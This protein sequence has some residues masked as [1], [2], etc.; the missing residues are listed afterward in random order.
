MR[1]LK[2]ILLL[3]FV[4]SATQILVSQGTLPIY[5][6]YLSDN[7]FMVHPS[8]AGIGNSAK[9]RMTHRQQWNSVGNSPSLQ[10]LSLHNAINENVA[11]GGLVFNDKNGFHSQVGLQGAFAYHLNFRNVEA[12]NQLSFGLAASYVQNT[13]DQT[14]FSE[15]DPVVSQLV[16]SDSYFNADVSFAYHYLDGFAFLTVK[17]ILLNTRQ[18]NNPEF[19]SLNLRRYLFN[20]GYFIGRGENLQFE[21]SAMFQY[22]EATNEKLIDLNAKVYQTFGR[23]ARVW[24][25]LSYRR[26]LDNNAIQE[27]SVLTPI[28]GIEFNRFLISYTYTH[29]L[30]GL[31]AREGGFHQLTLGINLLNKRIS[32]RGY[33]SRYNSFLYKTDN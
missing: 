26:S 17:N 16:E 2:Y 15:F 8:A 5:S 24:F 31:I 23:T 4:A 10:T 11:L 33:N 3:G 18:V 9:L 25:A 6:D 32:N 21:P 30:S 19:R 13:L 20:L 29:Q 27:L 28:A 12:L 1:R 14:S 22:I 7:I